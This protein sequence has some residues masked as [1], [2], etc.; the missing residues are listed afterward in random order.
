MSDDSITARAVGALLFGIS[1]VVVPRMGTAEVLSQVTKRAVVQKAPSMQPGETVS[2]S[3]VEKYVA[4]YDAMHRNRKLT[5]QEAAANQNLSVT[6]FRDLERKI[7]QNP[8]ALAQ[9]R[10]E[11]MN[12]ATHSSPP[13]LANPE[14]SRTH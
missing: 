2:S 13:S 14:P 7:E 1:A 5:L 11:L 9:A 4:V 6:A 8:T 10:T 12:R 3:E